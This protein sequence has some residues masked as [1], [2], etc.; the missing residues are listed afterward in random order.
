[1]RNWMIQ[2]QR[3][4]ALEEKWKW[5]THRVQTLQHV[6]SQKKPLEATLLTYFHYMWQ[7]QQL[8]VLVA[9]SMTSLYEQTAPGSD[10]EQALKAGFLT[11]E[12]DCC[13]YVSKR[14]KASQK[15][16]LRILF[17]N[18]LYLNTALTTAGKIL[19]HANGLKQTCT[20]TV[21]YLV[22]YR[23]KIVWILGEM[24]VSLY[25]KCPL[26]NV[27]KCINRHQITV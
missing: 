5:V 2:I 19:C 7:V 13:V 1:M 26:N 8:F 18:N 20:F 3:S 16:C 23:L 21:F 10:W 27:T 6:K 14:F 11:S 22:E 24:L 15:D 4:T 17:R 9:G 25:N 12:E